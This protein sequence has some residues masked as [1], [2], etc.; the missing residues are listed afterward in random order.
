MKLLDPTQPALDHLAPDASAAGA[1]RFGVLVRLMIA[2]EHSEIAGYVRGE[3]R[4]YYDAVAEQIASEQPAGPKVELP[5]MVWLTAGL[6]RQM[7]RIAKQAA[8]DI[9]GNTEALLEWT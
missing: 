2:A 5:E 7:Q 8:R 9:A 3:V 6:G 1:L 4:S